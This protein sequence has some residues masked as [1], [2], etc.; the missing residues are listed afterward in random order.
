MHI[1]NAQKSKCLSG[2]A[3][4]LPTVCAPEC[5]VTDRRWARETKRT[6]LDRALL[7]LDLLEAHELGAARLELQ[8]ARAAA[9]MRDRRRRCLQRLELLA[10]RAPHS[11]PSQLKL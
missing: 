3:A 9:R 8:R 6:Y 4:W 10:W 11:P 1:R 7:Q 5:T 2:C